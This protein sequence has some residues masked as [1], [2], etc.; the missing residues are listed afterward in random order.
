RR[1]RLD[2]NGSPTKWIWRSILIRGKNS[3]Y[4]NG[5]AQPG[6]CLQEETAL[7]RLH[8][9][10]LGLLGDGMLHFRQLVLHLVEAVHQPLKFL[11]HAAEQRRHLGVLEVL[12][13]RNDVV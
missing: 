11:G 12:E 9:Q 3:G 13:F 10:L 6:L 1:S 4:R 8:E 7:V 2:I 5:K